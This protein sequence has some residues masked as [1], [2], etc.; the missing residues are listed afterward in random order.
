MRGVGPD[1]RCAVNSVS[2]E[3]P[4]HVDSMPSAE[5]EHISLYH[6]HLFFVPSIL[7]CKRDVR[8]PFTDIL[9]CAGPLVP[10]P[11]HPLIIP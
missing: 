6:L 9:H 3:F 8:I 5:Y 10:E 7:L 4:R 11:R 2:R 1:I